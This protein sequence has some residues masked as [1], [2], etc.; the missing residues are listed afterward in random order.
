MLNK[1]IGFIVVCVIALLGVLYNTK[2]NNSL[3]QL[4]DQNLRG[5]VDQ[6]QQ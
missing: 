6:K 2:E 1:K 3:T 5:I 4:I